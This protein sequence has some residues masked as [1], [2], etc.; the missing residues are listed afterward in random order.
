MVQEKAPD[1]IETTPFEEVD[2][3]HKSITDIA[4]EVIA[5]LW[6]TGQ[7][8]RLRLTEAGYNPRDVEKEVVRIQ[9]SPR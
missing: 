3:I 9:N 4:Q 6:G 8:R 2:I 1:V 7:D 5:G